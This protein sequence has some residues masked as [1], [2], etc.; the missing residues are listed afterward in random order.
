MCVQPFHGGP[1]RYLDTVGID[2]HVDKM[3]QL[4]ETYN[5]PWFKP[6]QLLKDHGLTGEKFHSWFLLAMQAYNLLIN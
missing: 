6:C 3:K 2:K 5:A 1:L 4:E